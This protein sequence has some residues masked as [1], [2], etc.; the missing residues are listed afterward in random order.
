MDAG[1]E[2]ILQLITQEEA[3]TSQ[4][5]RAHTGFSHPE[6]PHLPPSAEDYYCRTMAD[7]ARMD[8]G[9]RRY[10]AG[11]R[12]LWVLLA[13]FVSPIVALLTQLLLM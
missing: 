12:R 4:S 11:T 13:L 2:T 8:A 5:S 3:Q 10:V 7:V 1:Q 9:T 6:P